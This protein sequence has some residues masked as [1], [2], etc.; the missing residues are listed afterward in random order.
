MFGLLTCIMVDKD[1]RLR[2]GRIAH[3]TSVWRE[4]SQ[5]LEAHVHSSHTEA[6]T[7]GLMRL[8]LL[9]PVGDGFHLS[10]HHD[11]ILPQVTDFTYSG[12]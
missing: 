12:T 10:T 1:D 5:V 2:H 4:N 6:S 11:P 9:L 7:L 3:H 8:H